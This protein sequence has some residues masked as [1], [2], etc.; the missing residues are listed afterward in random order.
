M[1]GAVRTRSEGSVRLGRK[2]RGGKW[3]VGWEVGAVCVSGIMM[4]M[5]M[6]MMWAVK[7]VEE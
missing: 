6:M 7:V 4:M 3:R 5:M 2:G 1:L